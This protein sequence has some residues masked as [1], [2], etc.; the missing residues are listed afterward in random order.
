M[1]IS[2]NSEFP[3]AGIAVASAFASVPAVTTVV[4]TPDAA[5]VD[6]MLNGVPRANGILPSPGGHTGGEDGAPGLDVG[7]ENISDLPPHIARVRR[8]GHGHVD[9]DDGAASAA[10]AWGDVH[11]SEEHTSELQSPFHLVCR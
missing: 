2:T 9:V 10:A 3:A 7:L 6:P 1:P 11:R 4:A 5:A 8:H